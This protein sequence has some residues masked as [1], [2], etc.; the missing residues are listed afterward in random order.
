MRTSNT[1]TLR[2]QVLRDVMKLDDDNLRKLHE[3]MTLASK[4]KN[5]VLYNLLHSSADE[6]HEKSAR[7]TTIEVMNEIDKEMGWK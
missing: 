4:K 5:P 1:D 7:Y 3:A 2:L 6:L